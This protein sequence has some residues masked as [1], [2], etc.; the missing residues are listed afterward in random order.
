MTSEELIEI[1]ERCERCSAKY[2]GEEAYK[3]EYMAYGLRGE[4]IIDAP[5]MIRDLIDHIKK[6]EGIE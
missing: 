5:V 1:E 4:F 6:L 2:V 3:N